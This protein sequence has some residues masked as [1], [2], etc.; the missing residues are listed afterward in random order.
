[1][2]DEFIKVIEDRDTTILLRDKKIKEHGDTIK[3]QGDTIK[4]QDKQLEEKNKKL[5]EKDKKL[6]EKDLL[7]GN[8]V[9][10]MLSQGMDAATVASLLGLSEE[11]VCSYRQ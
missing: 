3:E 11:E 4:E 1:M 6:A 7:L 9:R 10:R 2:E 8:A 5:E